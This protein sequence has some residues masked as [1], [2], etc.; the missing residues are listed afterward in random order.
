MRSWADWRKLRVVAQPD[1]SHSETRTV[2]RHRPLSVESRGG[3]PICAGWIVPRITGCSTNWAA[4]IF[5][6]RMTRRHHRCS[7]A[8][9]GV[10][11]SS[12]L[13]GI[14][15]RA[16]R[17]P[18][19]AS[20]ML[21]TAAHRSRTTMWLLHLGNPPLGCLRPRGGLP[22]LILAGLA[23]GTGGFRPARECKVG[24]VAG[25]PAVAAGIRTHY[26]LGTGFYMSDSIMSFS[27]GCIGAMASAPG[28]P[29]G[30]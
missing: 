25:P 13:F 2:L 27:A 8:L 9:E 19:V 4:C 12:G 6:P 28:R 17:E 18:N 11:G 3:F 16:E 10:D 30:M 21:S 7:P 29:D 5:T 1:Y 24:V 15:A 14:G 22:G 20:G 23:V 26:S